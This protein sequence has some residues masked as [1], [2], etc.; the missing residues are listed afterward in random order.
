LRE[1]FLEENVA[2]GA[3]WKEPPRTTQR[4][5]IIWAA[6]RNTSGSHPQINTTQAR[7]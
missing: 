6:A 5:R 2:L 1:W 3:R 7:N 4:S